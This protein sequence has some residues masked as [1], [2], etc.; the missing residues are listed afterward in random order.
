MRRPNIKATDFRGRAA[1]WP[2]GSIHLATEP[3]V[4]NLKLEC[5]PPVPLFP[6]E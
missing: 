6:G 3:I 4:D 5:F 1:R 2:L